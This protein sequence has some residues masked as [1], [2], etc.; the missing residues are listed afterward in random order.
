[1]ASF[2]HKSAEFIDEGW[3][4][5]TLA[6]ASLLACTAVL[7]WG[8]Y[9]EFCTPL[10]PADITVLDSMIR[11]STFP[12]T[13]LLLGIISCRTHVSARSIGLSAISFFT[14]GAI[15]L[16]AGFWT[17]VFPLQLF[18]LVSFCFAVGVGLSYAHAQVLLTRQNP[19]ST[20]ATIIASA[21]LSPVIHLPFE[22]VEPGIALVGVFVVLFPLCVFLFHKAWAT[23]PSL[24]EPPPDERAVRLHDMTI[25]LRPFFSTL[26][27][28]LIVGLTQAYQ[29]SN[30]MN[31]GSALA[32][33]RMGGLFLAGVVLLLVWQRSSSPMRL[34][35]LY[36]ALMML[37][38]TCYVLLPTLGTVFATAFIGLIYASFSIGSLLMVVTCCQFSHNERVNPLAVYG[39]FAGSIYLS[40]SLGYALG[41]RLFQSDLELFSTLTVIALAAVY[42][43]LSLYLLGSH[44]AESANLDERTPGVKPVNSPQHDLQ[45][46]ADV[47]TQFQN[48]FM[49]SERETQVVVL[50]AAGRSVPAIAKML[51]ISENTVRAHTKHIY[52]KAGVH[53][54][55]EL[56][57]MLERQREGTTAQPRTKSSQAPRSENNSCL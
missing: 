36:T 27:L 34:E 6:Y 41:A 12:L 42:S 13:L 55:Q 23:K 52:A 16:L 46:Q 11:K 3:L 56:L 7:H 10:V 39:L 37:T 47:F 1:M 24:Q 38:A 22:L 2:Q 8:S 45:T 25:F 15:A 29:S 53:T 19:S 30:L 49:L 40:M 9:V 5:S 18:S 50:L 57:D 33:I 54:K 20:E 51:S 44:K 31:G 21:I 32:V 17:D 43:I 14:V 48:L 4:F 35:P 28:S 26:I